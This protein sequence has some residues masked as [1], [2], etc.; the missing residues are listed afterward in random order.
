[1]QANPRAQIASQV[2]VQYERLTGANISGDSPR[3]PQPNSL[4][5]QPDI[6]ISFCCSSQLGSLQNRFG[7]RARSLHQSRQKRIL[8]KLN[9]KSADTMSRRPLAHI[10]QPEGSRVMASSMTHPS[11]T[12]HLPNPNP[13]GRSRSLYMCMYS[14]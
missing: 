5:L 14:L 6:L 12:Q 2:L 10:K 4:I 13:P 8:H 11:L 7:H 3:A 9:R 1:M